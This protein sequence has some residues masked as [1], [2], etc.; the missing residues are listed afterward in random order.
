[1]NRY[2]VKCY[3]FLTIFTIVNSMTCKVNYGTKTIRDCINELTEKSEMIIQISSNSNSYTECPGKVT[4]P[5]NVILKIESQNLNQMVTYDCTANNGNFIWISNENSSSNIVIRGINIIGNN[6]DTGSAC[7]EL[8]G[9]YRSNIFAMYNVTMQKCAGGAIKTTFYLFLRNCQFTNNKAQFGGA[10][11]SDCLNI[12]GCVFQGNQATESGGAI[13]LPDDSGAF[14]IENSEFRD[15]TASVNG[16]AINSGYTDMYIANSKFINNSA[17]IGGHLNTATLNTVQIINSILLDGLAIQS[18]GGINFM[19][20]CKLVNFT[21]ST[22]K[23][24]VAENIVGTINFDSESHGRKTNVISGVFYQDNYPFSNEFL[25]FTNSVQVL[26][27]IDCPCNPISYN[28]YNQTFCLNVQG[29]CKNGYAQVNNQGIVT[30]CNCVSSNCN[31]HD[32]NDN[33]TIISKGSHHFK[34]LVF[35]FLTVTINI[36]LLN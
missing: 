29:D 12:D 18:G 4:L 23:A 21:G 24:N 16:G 5:N 9:S 31:S 8:N 15:N 11:H 25:K 7:I 20:S 17:S 22:F 30:S 35:T 13:Y 6:L 19:E 1:M 2:I 26:N 28:E 3:I 10:I 34:S 33:S 27:L 36:Y 14:I 32:F